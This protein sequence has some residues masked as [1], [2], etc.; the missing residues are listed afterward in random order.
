MPASYQVYQDQQLL[1]V[2]YEGHHHTRQTDDLLPY[3]QLDP[4]V[5]TGM[6]CMIDC[7][8]LTSAKIDIDLRRQQMDRL[9]A[10][11][12][13]SAKD[14]PIVYYCPNKVS[15]SLTAMTAKM[16]A[17]YEGVTFQMAKT[18]E[19]LAEILNEPLDFVDMILQRST[20]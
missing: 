16:W 4:M 13:D 9:C 1:Y 17:E 7:E 2:R 11:L 5:M 10:L 18:R 8:N 15:Q 14:W 6:R 20:T 12:K 3:Y 19:E